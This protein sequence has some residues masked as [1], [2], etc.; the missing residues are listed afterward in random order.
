M[1]GLNFQNLFERA[2]HPPKG[3]LKRKKKSQEYAS[4]I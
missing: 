1:G 4:S 2:F 3:S